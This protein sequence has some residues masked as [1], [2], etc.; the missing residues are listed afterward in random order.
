VDECLPVEAKPKLFAMHRDFGEKY[1]NVSDHF[2]NKMYPYPLEMPDWI[3]LKDLETEKL[4]VLNGEKTNWLG[5]TALHRA[6]GWRCDANVAR[7]LIEAGV[8][9]DAQDNDHSG[10]TALHKAAEINNLEIGKVLI[11][12]GATMEILLNSSSDQIPTKTKI[13]IIF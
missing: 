5:E 7:A 1:E 10:Q 4:V 13:S 6:A 2:K 12:A 3:F 11:E 8:D 9:V